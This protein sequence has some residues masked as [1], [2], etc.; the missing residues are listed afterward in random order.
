MKITLFDKTKRKFS[1][2]N[3]KNIT[4]FILTGNGFYAIYNNKRLS[5]HILFWDPIFELDPLN[6]PDI[7]LISDEE[8]EKLDSYIDENNISLYSRIS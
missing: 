5:Q 8:W 1:L 2:R 6:L 7:L 4:G 3:F